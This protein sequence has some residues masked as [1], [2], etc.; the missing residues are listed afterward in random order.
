MNFIK[1]RKN[2]FFLLIYTIKKI[3]IMKHIRK[4]NEGFFDRFK[5]KKE[6]DTRDADTGLK[7]SDLE[8]VNQE[9]INQS[10]KIRQIVEQEANKNVN[11]PEYLELK[12]AI[13]GQELSKVK[14]EK[15]FNKQAK[16]KLNTGETIDIMGL[17]VNNY[18]DAGGGAYS[19]GIKCPGHDNSYY[20]SKIRDIV[21]KDINMNTRLRTD[22]EIM[23]ITKSE[24]D[25]LYS[26]IEE[27]D[28]W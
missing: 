4:F 16:V 19:Y 27:Q 22:K 2:R 26:F 17:F 25:E 12:D 11:S 28:K 3:N 24:F 13:L 14:I 6:D 9:R 8:T 5:S 7:L 18:G 1:K 15:S 20:A 23:L 21:R 10:N